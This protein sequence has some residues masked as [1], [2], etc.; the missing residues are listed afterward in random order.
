MIIGRYFSFSRLAVLCFISVLTLPA[1][2]EERFQFR[3]GHP[4]DKLPP[5]IK[6]VSGFGE[7][8]DWSADS[9]RILF[10]EKP[11][12]EVY[13]LDLET[14]LTHPKTRHFT[15]YGFTRAIYLAKWRHPAGR[16]EGKLRRGR[17]RRPQRG[18]TSVLAVG[19]AE[20]G[21]PATNPARHPGSG[22]PRR[23]PRPDANLVD[24]PRQPGPCASGK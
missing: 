14:G 20:G 11:M 21:K 18:P 23:F 5:Y 2:A 17:P 9:K 6:Q 19:F 22:G 15:H 13:E 10:V 4:V 3:D 7:R 24:A 8:P 1:F 16:S 12:G